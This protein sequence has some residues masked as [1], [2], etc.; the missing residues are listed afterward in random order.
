VP[1]SDLIILRKGR[2]TTRSRKTLFLEKRE[3]KPPVLNGC[4][5]KE[6]GKA[7]RAFSKKFFAEGPKACPAMLSGDGEGG[8]GAGEIE[9]KP[10]LC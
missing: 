1:P 10:G 9:R 6:S 5:G 7:R 8:K 4:K 2:A 3:G